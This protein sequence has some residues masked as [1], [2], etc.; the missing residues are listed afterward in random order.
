MSFAKNMN[1]A[2]KLLHGTSKRT[3]A[4]L[5]ENIDIL[6]TL[7]YIRWLP[8]FIKMSSILSQLGIR[9]SP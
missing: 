8:G 2:A 6:I 7:N 3:R 5:M 9:N 4:L 1:D